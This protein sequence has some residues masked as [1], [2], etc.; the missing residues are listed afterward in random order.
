MSGESVSIT[1]GGKRGR[2]NKAC[3]PNAPQLEDFN[4][5]GTRSDANEKWPSVFSVCSCENI[6]HKG[7]KGEGKVGR[8]IPNPPKREDGSAR[9]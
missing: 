3:H 4:R 8:I 7:T 6:L 9:F 1:K 5:E 2:T